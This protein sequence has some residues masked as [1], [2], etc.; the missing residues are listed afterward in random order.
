MLRLATRC[1]LI[2]CGIAGYLSLAGCKDPPQHIAPDL[3]K[4]EPVEYGTPIFYGSAGEGPRTKLTGWAP[5]EPHF[6]WSDGIAASLAI[7][8]RPTQDLVELHIKMAGMN[9]P[10]RVKHQRV[11]LYVNAEKLAQW[12]VA[13]EKVFTVTIPQKFVSGPNPLLLIDFYIPGAISPVSAGTGSDLRRLGVRLAEV[14]VSA[15]PRDAGGGDRDA[16]ESNTNP[17]SRRAT[18]PRPSPG[19]LEAQRA[20]L[21]VGQT[22]RP[23]EGWSP[24]RLQ[25]ASHFISATPSGIRRRI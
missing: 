23:Q 22:L 18:D 7:R 20:R 17:T 10:G 5:A 16:P 8:V 4:L 9:V 21:A 6:S 11:D 13:D 14:T 1:L 25:R 2:S 12:H 19:L 3:S 24:V 15:T